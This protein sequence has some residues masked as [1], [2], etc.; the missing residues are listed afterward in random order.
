MRRFLVCSLVLASMATATPALALTK[1]QTREVQE[2]LSLL[3]YEPGPIDGLYGKKSRNAVRAFQKDAAIGVDGI[4][5]KQTLR[6]LE[7]GVAGI[8]LGPDKRFA[9]GGG[10]I[11]IYEGVLSERLSKG[12]VDLASRFGKLTIS[13]TNKAGAYT[14]SFNGEVFATSPKGTGLPRISHTI[15]VPG[16]DVVLLT[17]RTSNKDCRVKNIVLA[18][19]EDGTT[20]PPT[21]IGNCEVALNGRVQDRQVVFSLPP[22]NVESWRLTES[23]VFENGTIEKR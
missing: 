17:A 9:S 11:D 8:N 21:E 10:N 6:A 2:K 14:V 13:K 23:W 7:E 12:S 20:L 4:V 3:G 5:G 16:T 18:V 15:E 1:A 22:K 19:N